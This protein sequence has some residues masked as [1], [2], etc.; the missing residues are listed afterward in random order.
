MPLKMA[1]P[2][3]HYRT[4][5]MSLWCWEESPVPWYPPVK[6]YRNH[7]HWGFLVTCRAFQA[8]FDILMC[9]YSV[10]FVWLI[11]MYIHALLL[12][13]ETMHWINLCSALFWE[14]ITPNFSVS[15]NSKIKFE[16]L[17]SSSSGSSFAIPP[18]PEIR[19]QRPSA[20]RLRFCTRGES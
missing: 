19:K 7:D 5:I 16:R 8:N 10:L 3:R 15:R 20:T 2:V 12:P 17:K 9:L 14:D 18:L 6:L 13:L 4:S 11:Y 1:D